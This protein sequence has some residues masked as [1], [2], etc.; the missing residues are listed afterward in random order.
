META[1]NI[2]ILYEQCITVKHTH[3][4]AL[5]QGSLNN[6]SI[7]KFCGC[8][9]TSCNLNKEKNK[10]NTINVGENMKSYP[11]TYRITKDLHKKL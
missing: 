8:D 2:F 6:A 7:T 1:F 4:N 5:V 10:N 3:L 11:F 9:L